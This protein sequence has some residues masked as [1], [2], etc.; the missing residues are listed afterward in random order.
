MGD[1]LKTLF[2]HVCNKLVDHEDD[3]DGS[4]YCQICSTQNQ[5]VQ[6]TAVDDVD[7]FNT[8]AGGGLYMPSHRR[9]HHQQPVP[10]VTK[11][12]PVSQNGHSFKNSLLNFIRNLSSAGE[13]ETSRENFQREDFDT[14]SPSVPQDFGSSKFSNF[15]EYYFNLVRIMYL[16]GLQI[17]IEL[18]CE[19]LVKE[20]KVTPL[21]CGLVSPI[22]LRLLSSTRVLDDWASNVI[23]ESE[24]QKQGKQQK[25]HKIR[26]TYRA[27]PHNK[28]GQRDVMIWF[29]FLKKRIP[30]ACTVAVSFLACH[31]AREA[32]LPSD[33]MKWTLEGKLPYFSSFV[34]IEKRMRNALSAC[35][36]SASVMFRPHQIVSVQKLELLAASIAQSI[37][38][39]L[40]PVNFYAI[41]F[42]YLQKLHLSVEKILSYACRIH[43]WSMLPDLWLSLSK[44][45]F[46]LP[47]H[48]CVMTILV[49]AIRIL[50]NIN[51]FGEW[52]KSLSNNDGPSSKPTT[53]SRSTSTSKDN[54]EMGIAF[55]WHDGHGCCKDSDED[56]VGLQDSAGLLRHLEAQYNEIANI[57]ESS[58]DLPTYLQYC[59]NVVFAGSEPS[60]E[61]GSMIENILKIF[62]NEEDT[63]PS[64]L[65]KEQPK[66]SAAV[67]GS[68]PIEQSNGNSSRK[69]LLANEA[70]R[71]MKL[72]M[73]ENRFCYIPPRVNLKRF[74]YLH[75]VRKRDEGALTYVAHADYYILLRACAKVAQV[76]IRILHIG[77]LSLERRLAWLENRINQCLHSEPPNATCQFCNNM[78]PENGANDTTKL[79]I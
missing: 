47:T 79:N 34:E 17:M 70:I 51:G 23:K 56:P 64:E 75:Y 7:L 22:W 39:E 55:A 73:E 3:F 6:D 50:Y 42:R 25:D 15:E 29:R 12:Q 69:F 26:S 52:E 48:I 19:A 37:G 14:M 9:R 31:V 53:R 46:S 33:I 59:K 63:K 30:L 1:D 62:M 4:F 43:E 57:Y 61:E 74:D 11:A 38:L 5:D 77:V 45:Y 72:D 36:I 20:F 58:K 60:F 18:Q 40:P 35:P 78:V 27:E 16:A 8:I 71:K 67:C 68:E 13:S 28:F 49:V 24:V 54:G 65:Q 2:C 76:D 44:D 66:P 10:V 41:A 32:V 21:I